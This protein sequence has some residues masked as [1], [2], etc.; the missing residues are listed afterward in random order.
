MQ[1]PLFKPQTEWLPPENFPDLSKYDD[2]AIDLE[3]KDPD[4]MKMGSGSI[5]GNGDVVGIAVAVEG[6]RGYYPIAHEGG[7]NIDR[8]KVLKWFQGA[9][10]DILFA[11]DTAAKYVRD[12]GM[13]TTISHIQK[14][15]AQT[16]HQANHDIDKTNDII[17]N[18][19][20][21][22][23]KR[24][25]DFLN[26]NIVVYKILVK[27]AIKNEGIKISEFLDICNKNGLKL[28]QKEINDK[29]IYSYEDKLSEFLK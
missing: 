4:L 13:D 10:M 28:V 1:I 23:K 6:W 14:I 20:M 24:A 27:H 22:E 11:T 7:G 12:Y 26:Q 17:E 21:E 18:L 9:Q 5:V 16:P 3:T 8:K 15:N 29:L 25:R 2:I 19:I